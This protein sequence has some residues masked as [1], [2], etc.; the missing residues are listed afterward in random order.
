[1]DIRFAWTAMAVADLKTSE[2]AGSASMPTAQ[3]TVVITPEL[4]V[5]PSPAPNPTPSPAPELSPS[6][7][8]ETTP[9]LVEPTPE[10]SPTPEASQEATA[11]GSL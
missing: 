3:P 10:V 9:I 7:T 6:P 11:G 2:G 8:P 4:Q 1:M 5:T